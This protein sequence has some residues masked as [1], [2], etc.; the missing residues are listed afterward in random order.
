[1]NIIIVFMPCDECIIEKLCTRPTVET[2]G[3]EHN[4]SDYTRS[5]GH[6]H[7]LT[8]RKTSTLLDCTGMCCTVITQAADI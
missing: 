5:S 8:P 2:E 6:K 7:Y 3:R 1:M 4:F